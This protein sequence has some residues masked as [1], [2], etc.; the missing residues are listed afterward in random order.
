MNSGHIRPS[1]EQ[2]E[3]NIA[4][5]YLFKDGDE[6]HRCM[7][8]SRQLSIVNGKSI[9][10]FDLSEIQVIDIE[11]KKLLLPLVAG[12]ILLSFVLVAFSGFSLDPQWTVVTLLAGV[13]VFYLG[14]N[15]SDVLH[16]NASQLNYL[17]PFRQHHQGI[18]KFIALANKIRMGMTG[19]RL[20]YFIFLKKSDAEGEDVLNFFNFNRGIILAFEFSEALDHIRKGNYS[21]ED[22]IFVFNPLNS[23]IRIQYLP[24]YDY[25]RIRVFF[26]DRLMLEDFAGIST[27]REF[28]A[29]RNEYGSFM[30]V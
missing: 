29:T 12:G 4:V 30:E 19:L 5:C 21:D 1:G 7:L 10:S 27:V 3:K 17:F 14:W 11:H 13:F 26:P 8:T 22:L 9:E 24:E 16:I 20:S 25:N 23:R 28:L 15:G 2:A 6:R 18:R